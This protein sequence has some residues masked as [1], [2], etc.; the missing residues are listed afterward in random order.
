M[1]KT[2]FLIIPA[3]IVTLL[4]SCN[5]TNNQNNKSSDNKTA[6]K[7]SVELTTL[8][9]K[10]YQWHMTEN[11]V[12]FPYKY[13]NPG[14]TIFVGIDWDVYNKNIEIFKK[15]NFFTDDFLLFH[16]TIASYIDSSIKKA[17]IK[18][19]NINDGIPLWDSDADDWCA[20]QD[21]PDNYWSSLTI[22]SLFIKEGY[23][24]FKWTWDTKY[25]GQYKVTAKREDGKWKI[26]SL[27]GFNNYFSVDHY[28]KIMNE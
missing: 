22:D 13:E 16:R 15:T 14:D 28:D 10:V 5:G 25:N 4:I 11:L 12:D 21:Y 27:D 23:A 24:Y 20:C 7:D 1:I 18:W 3:L 9:R 26:N 2:N 19:R 8:V 17:D 6:N